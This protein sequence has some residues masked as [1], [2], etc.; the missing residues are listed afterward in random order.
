MGGY[1]RIL[2]HI[3]EDRPH[4]FG[5][6]HLGDGPPDPFPAPVT[7]AASREGSNGLLSRLMVDQLCRMDLVTVPCLQEKRPARAGH[8]PLLP[9]ASTEIYFQNS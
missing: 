6:Q 7:S 1:D 3:R 4:A 2:A 9:K 8:A 5:D